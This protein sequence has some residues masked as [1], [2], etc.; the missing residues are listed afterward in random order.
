MTPYNLKDI[1]KLFGGTFCMNRYGGTVKKEAA[2]FS[3]T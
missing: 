3:E 2:G 1:F